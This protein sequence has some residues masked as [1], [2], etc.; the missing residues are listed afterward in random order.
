MHKFNM[1]MKRVEWGFQYTSQC[2]IVLTT[3]EISLHQ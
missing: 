1:G 2:K 3:L